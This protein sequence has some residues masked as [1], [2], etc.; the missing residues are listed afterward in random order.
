MEL[1]IEI[2]E[3][4]ETLAETDLDAKFKAEKFMY[5][6]LRD[7]A[8]ISCI[9]KNQKK[10]LDYEEAA[11]MIYQEIHDINIDFGSETFEMAQLPVT[12][13]L[14]NI[15]VFKLLMNRAIRLKQTNID[16][17][18]TM[19]QWLQDYIT[20]M[21]GY[22]NSYYKILIDFEL[23]R[24]YTLKDDLENACIYVEKGMDAIKSKP[25]GD[26][27]SFLVDGYLSQI[28]YL[29][30]KTFLKKGEAPTSEDIERL[31]K[32]SDQNIALIR[33][34]NVEKKQN[35]EE[36]QLIVKTG[37]PDGSEFVLEALLMHVHILTLSQKSQQAQIEE[38]VQGEEQK[39]QGSDITTKI[40]AAV[41]EMELI[42]MESYK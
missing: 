29:T 38:M 19:F 8:R 16:A 32:V 25:E 42:Q 24:V 5:K 20:K 6:T 40:D 7:L 33:Q 13:Q 31:L 12:G 22:D 1:E 10:M 18:L 27:S 17:A 14:I 3:H 28:E 21:V 30:N 23:S 26:T 37:I 34:I 2:D 35:P 4:L 41:Q 9:I 39:E 36:K 11:I 15:K